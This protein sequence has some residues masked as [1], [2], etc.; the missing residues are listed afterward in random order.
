M[1]VFVSFKCCY[2]PFS[3]GWWLLELFAASR[4]VGLEELNAFESNSIGI[5]HLLEL[6][7]CWFHSWFLEFWHFSRVDHIRSFVL[8]E[9]NLGKR[10]DDCEWHLQASSKDRSWFFVSSFGL[11]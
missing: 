6:S 11:G 5:T 4:R 9:S 3:A 7:G 10:L 2:E 8:V 1:K